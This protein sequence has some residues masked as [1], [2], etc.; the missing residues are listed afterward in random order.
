MMKTI[1]EI[2][3]KIQKKKASVTKKEIDRSLDELQAKSAQYVPVEDRGVQ[4]GD[5]VVT[6]VKSKDKKMKIGQGSS[7]CLDASELP[8]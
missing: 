1:A 3:E 2:N 4:D 5:Y 6:E 7:Y 8:P